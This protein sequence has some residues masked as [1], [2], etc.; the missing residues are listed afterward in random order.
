MAGK[1]HSSPG[2]GTNYL[3]LPDD[4]EY[5][6]NAPDGIH[7]ALRATH[8]RYSL[9]QS[10][11]RRVPCVACETE[12]RV[13]HI[14]VPA[15]T[16]CPTS[17]W[18][19]EYKGY[20]VSM[21][22]YNTGVDDFLDNYHATSYICLDSNSESLTSKSYKHNYGSLLYTTNVACS[23]NSALHNCPPYKPTTALSCV[24]CSK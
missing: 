10:D 5:D 24:V 14:M 21:A 3:C 20:I 8:Y 6:P 17:E 1:H 15:K 2:G 9:Y 19:L 18:K 4:P 22:E 13:N 23:G 16:R 11:L 12:K 7:T